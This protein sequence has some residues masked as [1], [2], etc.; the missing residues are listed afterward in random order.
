MTG[1]PVQWNDDWIKENYD[2]YKSYSS[3]RDAYN[4]MFNV[5]VSLSAIKN[6]THYKLGLIKTRQNCRHYTEE[7]IQW[8]KDHYAKLGCNETLRLFNLTFHENRTFHSMKNFG[9][10]YGIQVESCVHTQNRLKYGARREGSKRA[11]RPI[12][13]TRTDCG[14]VV[15]KTE[16]GWKASGKATWEQANGKVPNGYCITHLDGNTKNYDIKNLA[17]VPIQYLGLLQQ[18]DLRS[19]IPEITK[20][21]IRW[22]DLYCTAKKH[23]IKVEEIRYE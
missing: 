20:I 8:L 4:Q 2:T 18:H 23:G 15:V 14:R 7:Q 1:S 9:H 10:E 17:L 12:G 13:A 6:H 11:L 5:T 3:L 21:G 16:H 19:E 22:C